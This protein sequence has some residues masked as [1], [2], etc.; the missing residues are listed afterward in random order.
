MS[1]LFCGNVDLKPK[2]CCSNDG[3]RFSYDTSFH[4]KKRFWL[5]PCIKVFYF[6]LLLASFF[7]KIQADKD[8]GRRNRGGGGGGG[9]YRAEAALLF[10]SDFMGN[11]NLY[12]VFFF[13]SASSRML[14]SKSL[15]YKQ[16]DVFSLSVSF[17]PHSA[18]PVKLETIIHTYLPMCLV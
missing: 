13:F 5:V 8:Y 16:R 9:G 7:K 10:C 15:K 6:P 2:A 17:L 18:E 4:K 3:C 12:F 11:R 14:V 1:S